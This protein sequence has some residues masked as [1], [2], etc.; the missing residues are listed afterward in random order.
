M[1]V[2]VLHGLD[3]KPNVG[4]VTRPTSWVT[5][6]NVKKAI[7]L[8]WD[9]FN[10]AREKWR[11]KAES[12]A[13]ADERNVFLKKVD[14]LFV[15]LPY[16]RGHRPDAGKQ[17]L[18]SSLNTFVKSVGYRATKNDVQEFDCHP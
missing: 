4:G 2:P 9:A 14:R 5:I 8:L 12:I 13:H 3:T 15:T 7:E 18:A 6:P 11:E 17:S 16:M 10:F 1:I